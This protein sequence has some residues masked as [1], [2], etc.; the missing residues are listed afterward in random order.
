MPEII[1]TLISHVIILILQELFFLIEF[2]L[3]RLEDR[4]VQ[5]RFIQKFTEPIK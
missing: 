3:I 4:F 2:F 5:K 1:W